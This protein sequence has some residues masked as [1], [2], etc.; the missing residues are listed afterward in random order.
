VVHFA[1]LGRFGGRYSILSVHDVLDHLVA[2]LPAH[3][4]DVRLTWRL[5]LYQFDLPFPL[6]AGYYLR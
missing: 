4:E 6:R 3:P 5:E 2:T 1:P